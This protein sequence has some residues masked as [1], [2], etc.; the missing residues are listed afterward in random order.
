MHASTFLRPSTANVKLFRT[1]MR[2]TIGLAS[3]CIL[4]ASAVVYAG[5]TPAVAPQS[6]GTI[7]TLSQVGPRGALTPHACGV[8]APGTYSNLNCQNAVRLQNDGDYLFVDMKVP[9]I[10]GQYSDAL[11]PRNGTVTLDHVETTGG[12]WFEGRDGRGGQDGWTIKW[13]KLYGGQ[14]QAMRPKGP[15]KMYVSDSWLLSDGTPPAGTHTE[16]LQHMD[17]ANAKYERVAFSRQPVSNN[18]VTAVL[19][20]A[21]IDVGADTQFIDCEVGYFN[22]SS[23]ERGGGYYAIYPSLSQ[24]INPRIHASSASAFYS[25]PVHLV[26][27][28]YISGSGTPITSPM[29]TAPTTTITPA[30]TAAPTTTTTLP[31][32]T[33]TIAP[34]T[35]VPP[36]TTSPTTTRP[37]TTTTT[38]TRPIPPTT[39]PPTTTTTTTTA[40]PPPTE[41]NLDIALMNMK[42]DYHLKKILVKSWSDPTLKARAYFYKI[43]FLHIAADVK[44]KIT[45]TGGYRIVAVNWLVSFAP[46]P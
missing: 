37:A 10:K 40:P 25:P 13:S 19:T 1:K 35:T 38:T 32:P 12:L 3:S 23:W 29:T 26:N 36:T 30:T 11:L 4:I 17:N 6:T 39:L 46:I 41:S 24:W 18:T 14:Y 33:T 7:P 27:P 21:G 15:S 8:L 42:S 43:G 20:M 2:L 44:V 9:S 34:T 31:A 16:V 28:T 22:G 45:P 5:T